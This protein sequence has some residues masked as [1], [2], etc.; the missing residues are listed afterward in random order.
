MT[1][2]VATQLL[3]MALKR[4]ARG[5][6]SQKDLYDRRT[7]VQPIPDLAPVLGSLRW[8]L[9]GGIALRAYAPERMTLD[10]DII[11]HERDA[12]SAR[13]AFVEAGYEITGELSIGGFTAREGA[14]D[15]MP[16]DVILRDDPWL[17]VALANPHLDPAGHPVL[18]R[19]YLTLL[20]L[21]AGRALDVVDVQRLLVS[22]PPAER[23]STRRL[24]EAYAPGLAEDYDSLVAL[25]DLEFG[26]PPEEDG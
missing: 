21:Q 17:E 16:V 3:R 1:E 5:T 23:A 22:T 25:A 24:V 11:M 15:A 20:K 26:P 7:S 12:R 14:P 8:A 2:R 4:G 19:P 13:E 9:V 18:P 10:V 6:G